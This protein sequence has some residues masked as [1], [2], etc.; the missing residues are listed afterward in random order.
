[1]EDVKNTTKNYIPLELDCLT[2]EKI[3]YCKYE[4]F[5]G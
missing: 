3:S 5:Y 4:R 2:K 1:M